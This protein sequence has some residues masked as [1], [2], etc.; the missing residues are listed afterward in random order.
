MKV[1]IEFCGLFFAKFLCVRLNFCGYPFA[2]KFNLYIHN[3][4]HKWVSKGR[5]SPFGTRFCGT[6]SLVCYTFVPS[7]VKRM[8][9]ALYDSRLFSGAEQADKFSKEQRKNCF[10]DCSEKEQT[11]YINPRRSGTQI[12][13]FLCSQQ[14]ERHECFMQ[15][16]FHFLR[17]TADISHCSDDGINHFFCCY[18]SVWQSTFAS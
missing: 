15:I 11:V 7:A 18:D 6:Q 9:V 8:S 1:A 14:E 12:L 10:S 4:C 5:K 17:C 16:V 2:R 13:F 3:N